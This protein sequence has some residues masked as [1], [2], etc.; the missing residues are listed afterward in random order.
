[1]AE[2][3]DRALDLFDAGGEG[4]DVNGGVGVKG[5]AEFFELRAWWWVVGER[6]GGGSGLGWSE[7]GAR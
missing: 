2:G 1:M 4:A 7:G 6:R 5:G 3:A